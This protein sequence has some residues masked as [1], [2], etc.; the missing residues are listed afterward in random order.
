LIIVVV[1]LDVQN[2]KGIILSLLCP[3]VF[4][5]ITNQRY[6]KRKETKKTFKFPKIVKA[7]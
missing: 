6:N 7:K 2:R 3:R 5:R 4:I 1:P